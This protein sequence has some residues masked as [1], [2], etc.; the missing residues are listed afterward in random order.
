MVGQSGAGR[1]TALKVFEDS[2]FY[3]MDNIPFLLLPEIFKSIKDH[4]FGHGLYAIGLSSVH[5]TLGKQLLKLSEKA[6][7]VIDTKTL[8]LDCE[9]EVLL[10][11]FNQTRRRHPMEMA[12]SSI[13]EWIE[14]EST[15]NEWMR[16]KAD[17]L[18]D[19]TKLNPH[20]LKRTIEQKFLLVNREL[21]VEFIS[22]GFKNAYQ[23]SAD[24]VFDVRCL[25]N[26]YFSS[27]LK[28][29]NGTNPKVQQYVLKEQH[30]KD[31][32]KKIY[33]FV[34]D[35]IPHYFEEG[36]YYLRIAIG[37]TGG[38]H[39]SVSF[40]EKLYEDFS[41]LKIDNASF[42]KKHRDL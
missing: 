24:I 42:K 7:G 8:F 27:D 29:E 22:F 31:F 10:K 33:E 4:D 3:C 23:D 14:I 11:R 2:G 1:S 39:R 28:K 6:K 34:K 16:S 19:T 17:V 40:V 26:P 21:E 35:G 36:K 13:R 37:C 9:P 18:I 20:E 38:Q 41:D 12:G 5:E 15:N 30:S 32:Y 25:P